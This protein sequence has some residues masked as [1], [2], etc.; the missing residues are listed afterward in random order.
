MIITFMDQ[1]QALGWVL[2]MVTLTYVYITEMDKCEKEMSEE[3]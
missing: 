3:N 1:L 2:T